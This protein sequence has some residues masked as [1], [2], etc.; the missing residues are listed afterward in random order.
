MTIRAL[1][2]LTAFA[3]LVAAACQHWPWEQVLIGGMYAAFMLGVV[4]LFRFDHRQPF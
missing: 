2:M 4:A 1:L 3:A